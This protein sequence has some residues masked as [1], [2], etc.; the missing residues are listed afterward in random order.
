MPV[1]RFPTKTHPAVVDLP[2]SFGETL[3]SLGSYPN[4]C[5][6]SELAYPLPQFESCLFVRAAR[7]RLEPHRI[8]ASRQRPQIS[9]GSLTMHQLDRIINQLQIL[10]DNLPE[11]KNTEARAIIPLL[12][13]ID[14]QSARPDAFSTPNCTSSSF[15]TNRSSSV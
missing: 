13:I 8:V 15:S 12:I 1:A 4:L 5:L 10:K 14:P 9:G 3:F 7:P 2:V 11:G 6:P